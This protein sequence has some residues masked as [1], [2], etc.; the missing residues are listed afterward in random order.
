MPALTISVCEGEIDF[1]LLGLPLACKYRICSEDTT[2]VN[3]TLKRNVAPGSGTPWFLARLL[4]YAKAKRLYTYLDQ[5]DYLLNSN[6]YKI[7][8]G[9]I[10]SDDVTER[11]TDPNGIM[12][13]IQMRMANELA[14]LSTAA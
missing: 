12:A 14:C 10:D 5:P 7:L 9:G 2:F 3:R 1:D 8:Y 4:G 11:I 13:N 6:E